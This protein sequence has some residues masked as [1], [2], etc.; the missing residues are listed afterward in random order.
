MENENPAPGGADSDAPGAVAAAA[1]GDSPGQPIGCFRARDSRRIFHVRFGRST[2]YGARL[3]AGSL[4]LV[5]TGRIEIQDEEITLSGKRRRP[6]WFGAREYH[7]LSPS[8]VIN[9]AR[10]GRMIRFDISAPSGGD[11]FAVFRAGSDAEADAIVALLPTRQTAAFAESQ[12]ASLDFHRRLDKFS[13]HAP[14]TPV[15]VAINA[16][17][18]VAMCASGVGFFKPTGASVIPWGTNFGPLTLDGQ[19]WRLFTSMFVHFGIIHIAMNMWVLLLAGRMIER[20]FGSGRF[21][22]LYLFAGLCASMTSLLWNPL[23]NSAGASGAI[24]GLFGGFL[25]FVINP[26]NGVPVSV[27]KEHRNSTLAFV[28][29]NLAYGFAHTGIDNAAHVGGLLSGFAIGFLLAR[30]LDQASR[31]GSHAGRL[32]GIATAGVATLGLLGVPLIRPSGDVQARLRFQRAVLHLQAQE[33]AAVAASMAL[34]GKIATGISISEF[35]SELTGDVIPKWGVPYHALAAV[36]LPA[37]DSS[38]ALQQLLLR[39]FGDRYHEFE[40]LDQSIVMN[41]RQ[42]M[43]QVAADQADAERT[44]AAIKKLRPAR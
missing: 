2:G 28:A 25:A 42:M 33:Q 40:S 9:V 12:A 31:D 37:S 26:R 21:A 1:D 27:M 17:V 43:Q 24:F 19:W 4:R 20:M 22:L 15:L 13:P 8:A 38:Y 35:R 18:F 23:V 5:G 34:K 14:V 36:K 11:Q 41:D 32:L 7:N 29:M 44:M 10:T 30:P 16:A 6:F 3:A 39:Y